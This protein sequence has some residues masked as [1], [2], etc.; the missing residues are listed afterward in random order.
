MATTFIIAAYHFE[1][2]AERNRL[3]SICP[4]CTSHVAT[5]ILELTLLVDLVTVHEIASKLV[6]SWVQLLHE[7]IHMPIELSPAILAQA[8]AALASHDVVLGPAADGG[9]YLIG[10]KR[11]CAALFTG[12]AW[13]ESRVCRDTEAA[14]TAEGLCV[15]KLSV[16]CDVDRPEDMV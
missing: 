3:A 7:L 1:R 11:P 16:L 2:E 12:I 10:V 15:A 5:L 6:Q 4:G 9:Y 8:N 13:G 14:A